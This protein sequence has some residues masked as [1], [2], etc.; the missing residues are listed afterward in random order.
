[1]FLFSQKTYDILAKGGEWELG[2]DSEGIDFDLNRLKLI[3]FH[4]D[5]NF[6]DLSHDLAI[7]HMERDFK[8]NI[9][10]QQLCFDNDYS[11]PQ[12][13]DFCI[14]TGWGRDALATH[15][16]GAIEHYTVVNIEDVEN[17]TKYVGIR[18]FNPDVSFCGRVT[19]DA[20]EFDFGSALA[21]QKSP[22]SPEF[23][24]K[25]I[26]THNTGCL[27]RKPTLV[28]A[29]NDPEWINSVIAPEKVKRN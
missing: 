6:T 2:K 13:G 5:F 15:K 18:S 16:T 1:M 8:F 10:I 24:L 27:S 23:V 20:C 12:P 22:N 11:P 25:G 17:C 4:P 14:V 3:S 7:L 29:K 19:T 26:Y 9:H 28:F 21:C